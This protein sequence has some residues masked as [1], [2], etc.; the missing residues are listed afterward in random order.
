MRK[1]SGMSLFLVLVAVASFFTI[2]MGLLRQSSGE[3]K[4]A[5]AL[6][7]AQKAELVALS[8]IDWADAQLRLE[9]K[10]RW[11]QA[12]WGERLT[13]GRPVAG[14]KEFPAF[15][16]QS[17]SH[18]TVAC[19][20]VANS[21]PKP[22]YNG[23]KPVWLLHH[24]DVFS[25]GKVGKA[26]SLVY[27]KF[28]IS[29][30][31]ALNSDSTNALEYE[32]SELGSPYLRPIV[33][34]G[35]A[36]KFTIVRL[37][38]AIGKSI[39]INTVVAQLR[40]QG[41]GA[42]IEIKP[43]SN[44]IFK[45][46]FKTMGNSGSAGAASADSPEEWQV[47]DVIEPNQILGTYEKR[48]TT[49]SNRPTQAKTLKKMVRISK[50][51]L[52]QFPRFDIN[53]LAD[54]RM[55]A[56]YIDQVSDAFIINFVGH[57]DL[58]AQLENIAEE[59][60]P[61]TL[62]DNEV[63]ERFTGDIS[64]MTK[65][66]AQNLFLSYLLQKFTVPGCRWDNRE[67]AQKNSKLVLD[68]KKNSAPPD[69]DEVKAILEKN[70][71]LEL[72]YSKPRKDDRYYGL[73]LDKGEYLS[74]LQPQ[75]NV[76]TSEFVR[77]ISELSDA[78]RSVK[79][80]EDQ[81]ITQAKDERTDSTILV[82]KPDAKPYPIRVTVEK[83]TKS[84]AFVDEENEFTIAMKD[85]V[86][87]LRKYF[88]NEGSESP[89]EEVRTFQHVDWPLPKEPGPPPAEKAGFVTVW[90]PGK[91]G[92]PPSATFVS[93]GGTP[94]EIAY[95]TGG[96][97]DFME[98]DGSPDGGK[99]AIDIAETL[100][101]TENIQ[102]TPGGEPI[103]GDS[104]T[105]GQLHPPVEL[106]KDE[107][108]APTDS[109]EGVEPEEGSWS[110]VPAPSP[111][112]EDSS[113]WCTKCKA[114][115]FAAGTMVLM[116]DG[117]LK[118]IEKILVGDRVKTFDEL[119][120]IQKIGTVMGLD[121]PTR[122]HL[123]TIEFVDKRT[124]R[125][126]NEHPLMTKNGWAAI[127]PDETFS[128]HA[129][130]VKTLRVGDFVRDVEGGWR[131]IVSIQT[132]LARNRVHNLRKITEGNTYFADGFLAHNRGSGSSESE[133]PGGPIT[134]SG[135]TFSTSGVPGTSG[136]PGNAGGT[137]GHGDGPS[138]SGGYGS[139]GTSSPGG[140]AGDMTGGGSSGRCPECGGPMTLGSGEGGGSG[141]SS[142]G[143]DPT[144]ANALGTGNSGNSGA[145]GSSGSGGGGSSGSSNSTPEPTMGSGG[146]NYE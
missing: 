101:P 52:S 16:G 34:P 65:E 61:K 83:K 143:A 67:R 81:S 80:K 4:H 105:F 139:G 17:D 5:K 103:E 71:L 98:S 41:S 25:L 13:P 138:S 45:G 26:K 2:V 110:Y 62:Q 114:C 132:H 78:S 82:E 18:L 8:G 64:T 68:V 123:T 37:P 36:P 141:G 104:G 55:V 91:E 46:F 120:G 20:D 47:N 9:E 77:Q 113:S 96:G 126:T 86:T 54:R 73:K 30:E 127:D 11:Y 28:I 75:L 79:Y 74:L 69:P 10:A 12:P 122:F 118:P 142:G 89:K 124:L 50:I 72:L 146:G 133:T 24:I 60:L 97:R 53:Q 76:P 58:E 131:Q 111:G 108:F 33:V 63:L 35:G 51:D 31:P 57:N 121:A 107:V 14:V 38:V 94:V 116:A 59:S 7:E 23:F 70:G 119:K 87:F 136:N 95:P 90:T 15:D 27:G 106:K 115:C 32:H 48:V 144:G 140:L 40:P 128:A 66:R 85:L 130:K 44:G 3:L 134:S 112:G 125:L 19:Q 1:K 84:Y 93:K 99:G 92:T 145:S 21:V 56:D 43:E 49:S 135:G 100:P 137:A 42:V 117:S 102:Q 39:D 22:S 129:L 6:T 88:S 109:Q 29:P